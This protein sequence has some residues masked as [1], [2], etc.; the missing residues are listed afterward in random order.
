MINSDNCEK[1]ELLNGIFQSTYGCRRN[2]NGIIYWFIVKNVHQFNSLFCADFNSMQCI[3]KIALLHF[4]M[5]EHVD[6]K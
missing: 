5:A 1:S 2:F 3:T 6:F 4:A